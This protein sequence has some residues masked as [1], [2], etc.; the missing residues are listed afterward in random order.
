MDSRIYRWQGGV[1]H[2]AVTKRYRPNHDQ[3]FPGRAHT[4]PAPIVINDEKESEVETILDQRMRP[5]RGQFLV[6]W[7]GYPKSENDWEPV[8]GL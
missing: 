7:K 6:K 8:D 5:G 2:S 1:F 4:R 3:Q